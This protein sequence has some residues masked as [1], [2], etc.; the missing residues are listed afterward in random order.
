VQGAGAAFGVERYR[1]VGDVFL[2]GR[3]EART[4]LGVG[5]ES[6][7][8]YV[9]AEGLPEPFDA[10]ARAD[11]D[12]DQRILGKSARLDKPSRH[13]WVG[14]D[15][16]IWHGRVLYTS[17]RLGASDRGLTPP[18]AGGSQGCATDGEGRLLCAWLSRDGR[19]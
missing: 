18:R 9:V 19:P 6:D 4:F 3:L 5:F 16:E 10:A 13:R 14:D 17:A 2:G 7:G 1:Q 12:D 15:M 11:I 8:A